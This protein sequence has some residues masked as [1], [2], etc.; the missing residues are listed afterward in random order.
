M[1]LNRSLKGTRGGLQTKKG[2]NFQAHD[3]A[4]GIPEGKVSNCRGVGLER[5][6]SLVGHLLGM[7]EVLGSNPGTTKETRM[8]G[9]MVAKEKVT[10]GLSRHTLHLLLGP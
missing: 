7:Y 10:A 9:E 8:N 3:T 6:S 5:C 1:N 4:E 2:V